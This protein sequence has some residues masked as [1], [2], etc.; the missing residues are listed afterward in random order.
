VADAV[1]MVVSEDG[2][3]AHVDVRD[4]FI[5]RLQLIPLEQ[6]EAHLTSKGEFLAQFQDATTPQLDFFFFIHKY[7]PP[8]CTTHHINAHY[9][10][11]CVCIKQHDFVA[12]TLLA[13]QLKP[14]FPT[15]ARSASCTF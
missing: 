8:H 5:Q 13:F 9:S 7:D 12:P 2:L 11:H 10:L 6:F 3:M 4:A 14:I 1:G 15:R